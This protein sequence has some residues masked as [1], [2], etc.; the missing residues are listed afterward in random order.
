[1][2]TNKIIILA[3]TFFYAIIS[4]INFGKYHLNNT[5]WIGLSNTDKLL[6][7]FE[8]PTLVNKININYGLT[9]GKYH[10]IYNTTDG[11]TTTLRDMGINNFPP[12]Y[13]WSN[14]QIDYGKLVTSMSFIIDSTQV[15]IRQLAFFDNQNNY[16]TN[17]T[18]KTI[19]SMTDMNSLVSDTPPANIYDKWLS[20]TVFDEIYYVS[21]AKQY[22]DGVSPYVYVHPPL[23]MLIIAIGLLLLG[24]T[25]FAW[26]LIPNLFGI[27][28][29]PIVYIFAN[30]IFKDRRLATI[31][32]ILIMVEF[33]HYTISRLA[34]LD[35]I[36]TLFIVLDY[37]FLYRYVSKRLN[38]GGFKQSIKYLYLSALFLG[39]GIA[40]KLNATFSA[41][42]IFIWVF[43]CEV[44]ASKFTVKQI[45]T[46]GLYLLLIFT[47]I[48]LS[49]YILSYIPYYNNM[50]AN[51][52]FSFIIDRYQHMYA[53]QV[54]GLKNAT[55]PY[56]SKWWSWPLLITPM[57]ISYWQ[58]A[59]PSPRGLMSASIVLIG[60]PAIY[61]AS[62]PAVLI[63]I[64]KWIA[65]PN[66]IIA[67]ILVA[68]FAQYLPYAFFTRISFIYYFYP[69]T[70]FIILAI[71]YILKLAFEN[72]NKIY[73][74]LAYAY[75][76]LTIILFLMYF[77]VLSGLDIARD[78]TVKVL[79]LLK[80]WNF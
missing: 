61:W 53:Y 16:L 80:S 30:K 64:Y 29:V 9:T 4:F 3:L 6:V 46:K 65:K 49:V 14:L 57:S 52:I 63:L 55:H 44:I 74:Y 11:Q 18:V 36:L 7:T 51:N 77:P 70:P 54:N 48:P 21:S 40:T 71:V 37:Y 60:N 25:P 47:L 59:I 76:V 34:F 45:I 35:S 23:G 33:M 73:H 27:L 38:G 79:L 32:T 28:L 43:Y 20:S 22:I 26:R 12:H 41:P 10:I 8:S 39:F 75:I 5:S 69:V 67:F 78:Y 66:H 56:A 17:F 1:M 19:P 2:K 31:A 24:V 68:I 72:T 62:I 42:A 13:Q 50:H 58:E 15:E